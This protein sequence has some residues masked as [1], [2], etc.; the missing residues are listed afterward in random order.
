MTAIQ[1]IRAQSHSGQARQKCHRAY[2][3]TVAVPL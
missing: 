1:D 3:R 2:Y